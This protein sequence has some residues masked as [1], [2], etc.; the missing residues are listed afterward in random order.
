MEGYINVE[1]TLYV[2]ELGT[3]LVGQARYRGGAS[4]QRIRVF[5][6]V[7]HGAGYG[8]VLFDG[9]LEELIKRLE[10]ALME[11]LVILVVLVVV[12][13]IISR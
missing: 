8:D 12:L 6:Y 13:V 2:E 3:L 9:T 11:W 1:C 10:V 5:K 7:P 4:E